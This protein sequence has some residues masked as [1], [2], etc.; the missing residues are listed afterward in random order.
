MAAG[1]VIRASGAR[2]ALTSAPPL[3][4]TAP[5]GGAITL[6]GPAANGVSNGSY[7][8]ALEFRPG[9]GG[10]MAIN[11]IDL[12]SYVAGVISAEVPA[13][14]PAEALRTQAIAARTYAITT[15]A[16]GTQGFTQYAD[17]RSQMYRGVSAETPATSAAV[18]ATSGMVV[19]YQGKPVTTYFFSSSG[20]R[21]ENIENSFVGS[22]P[23]PWLKSV[24]DPYDSVSPSHRWGPTS[25]SL[26][27]ATA[28]LGGLVH[29]TLKWITVTRR[30]VSPRVVQARLTGTGGT[31]TVSGPQLRRAFGLRDAWMRFRSFSTDLTIAGPLAPGRPLGQSGGGAVAAGVR[32]PV[33][34]GSVRPARAGTWATVQRLQDGSW[35]KVADLLLGAGGRY[36]AEMPGPGTYRV[37]YGD[38]A[39]PA[40]DA[41]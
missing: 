32:R 20:G 2:A 17:T 35:T 11:A 26:A 10:L 6:A 29:G 21:T 31:T 3:R 15:N 9:A 5:D 4:I 8:G 33:L 1:A 24:A 25:I 18:A 12:E 30:G 16:G 34:Q 38:G 41:R 40:V 23:E 39:G 7:R 28:K 19:T 36:R 14:W 27:S 13:S 22:T 37:A